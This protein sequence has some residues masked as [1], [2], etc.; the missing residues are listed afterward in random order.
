MNINDDKLTGV[1]ANAE[2][3]GLRGL[4][5][6][7]GSRAVDRPEQMKGH[8]RYLPRVVVSIAYRQ[9][10]DDHV[11]VP[12]SL[13]LVDVIAFYDWIKQRVEARSTCRPPAAH[14]VNQA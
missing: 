10:A 13:H 14:T 7:C 6:A 1:N 3:E 12:Y 8:G 11:R 4:V 9:P 2:F 5:S